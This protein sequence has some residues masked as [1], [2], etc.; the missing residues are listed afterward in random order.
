[1][2]K[3]IKILTEQEEKKKKENNLFRL[4]NNLDYSIQNLND[5]KKYL[6]TNDIPDNLNKLQSR[7]FINRYDNFIL[8]NDILYYKNDDFLLEVLE[9]EDEKKNKVLEM[10]NDDKQTAN[11]VKSFYDKIK[12]KYCNITRDFI[13]K[14][15]NNQTNKQLTKRPLKDKSV[16]INADY[17]NMRVQCDL[18]D[19]NYWANDNEGNKFI[20]TMIDVF[21]R[22]VF[23]I[24]IKNK[25]N[26]TVL[27]AINSIF[28]KNNFY[29]TILQTDRGLEYKNENLGKYCKENKIK[30]IFGAAYTPTSNCYIENFNRILRDN[31]RRIFVKYKTLNYTEHL[32]NILYNRNHTKSNILRCRPIDIWRNTNTRIDINNESNK[33]LIEV[34]KDYCDRMKIKIEENKKTTF[35]EGDKVRILLSALYSNLRKLNKAGDGKKIICLWTTDIYIIDTVFKKK[36]EFSKDKYY[37]TDLNGEYIRQE[38]KKNNPNQTLQRKIFMNKEIQKIDD[39]YIPDTEDLNYI[40]ANILN[41]MKN[42][43]P[44]KEKTIRKKTIEP[45]IEKRQSTRQRKPTEKQIQLEEEDQAEISNILDYKILKNGIFKFKV[46]FKDDGSTNWTTLEDLKNNLIFHKYIE[47]NIDLHHLKNKL[48]YE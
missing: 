32:E 13:D 9:N 15:I 36:N 24:P 7:K 4:L 43:N 5:I 23:A 42:L 1:M 37:I 22:Y 10:Y 48:I 19:V 46:K 27:E 26:E 47:D 3:I 12:Y 39:D 16:F 11:G 35:K 40:E 6:V 38:F 34:Y 45:I 8:K 14:I 41:N 33:K 2:V 21:T 17:P 28:T 18:I 25:K 30:L 29:P 20:L 44:Q 31:I